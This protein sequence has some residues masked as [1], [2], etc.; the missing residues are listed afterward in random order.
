MKTK[1]S[2]I[3]YFMLIDLPGLRVSCILDVTKGFL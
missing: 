2:Q 1:D 3:S